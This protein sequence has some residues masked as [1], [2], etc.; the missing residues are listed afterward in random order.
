LLV[1]ASLNVLDAAVAA[2]GEVCLAGAAFCDKALPAADF[3]F[4]DVDRLL[5]VDEEFFAALEL[6]VFRFIVFGFSVDRYCPSETR[7]LWQLRLP[8]QRAAS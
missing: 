3:D 1:R 4:G 2:L 8:Q 6:V 7:I 5:S